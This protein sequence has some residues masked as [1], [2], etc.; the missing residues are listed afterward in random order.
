MKKLIFIFAIVGS[1][2]SA[3]LMTSCPNYRVPVIDNSAIIANTC[4]SGYVSVGNVD[5][6]ITNGAGTCWLFAPTGIS[7]S[8]D[9]GTYEFTEVC[10]YK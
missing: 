3:E 2:N 9:A 7:F 8:D 4:P 1:A 10:E 5:S 6:C